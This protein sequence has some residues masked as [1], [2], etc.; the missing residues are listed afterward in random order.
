MTTIYIHD[1][2]TYNFILEQLNFTLHVLYFGRNADWCISWVPS[3]WD[4]PNRK[5]LEKERERAVEMYDCCIKF[6]R[7]INQNS[8][9]DRENLKQ[10]Y[11]YI[12]RLNNIIEFLDDRI[13]EEEE[14]EKKEEEEEIVIIEDD[15]DDED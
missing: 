7:S 4:R 8:S 1:Q 15:D 13:E 11:L 14:K 12:N 2:E 3:D 5:A 10:V 6:V 9:F